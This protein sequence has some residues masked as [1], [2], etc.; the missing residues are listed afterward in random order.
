MEVMTEWYQKTITLK[1]RK[2]GCY[3]ITDEVVGSI[4]EDLKKYK[5]GMCNMFILH[6]SA[7]LSIN[8]NCDPTVRKDM[9]TVLN[10]LIPEGHHLYEH[11]D[12]GEDDMPA[13][14]KSML[15]GVSL[16]IPIQNGK[17]GLGTWQGI[18]LM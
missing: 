11:N 8:E 4:F 14:V 17:L 16:N 6:T 9:E 1:S 15:S 12:E 2:R 3:L 7:G 13:H 18:W 5:I 10:R